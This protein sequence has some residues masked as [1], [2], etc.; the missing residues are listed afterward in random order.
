MSL[1]QMMKMLFSNSFSYR[2]PPP[3]GKGEDWFP[4]VQVDTRTGNIRV[5]PEALF[6]SGKCREDVREMRA[7]AV[8]LGLG[9]EDLGVAEAKPGR[10]ISQK[11]KE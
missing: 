10:V 5:R 6:S 3:E 11:A 1:N 7:L 4:E 2:C 9:Q 8:R